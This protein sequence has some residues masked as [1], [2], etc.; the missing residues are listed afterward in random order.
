[1]AS[2][3]DLGSMEAVEVAHESRGSLLRREAVVLLLVSISMVV[4]RLV[5]ILAGGG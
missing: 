4:V 3:E 2:F 5:A 1:M